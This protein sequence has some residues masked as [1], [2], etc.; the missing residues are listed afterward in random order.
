MIIFNLKFNLPGLALWRF[1]LARCVVLLFFKELCDKRVLVF[2]IL[3][4]PWTERFVPKFR[5]ILCL[6]NYSAFKSTK[7]FLVRSNGETCGK[8]NLSIELLNSQ[9][10]TIRASEKFKWFPILTKVINW[11]Q[12]KTTTFWEK[13]TLRWPPSG[14]LES[15]SENRLQPN[16][17]DSENTR[18]RECK[19]KMQK[20]NVCK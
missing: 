13:R 18:S 1:I 4:W 14:T 17:L 7:A 5:K 3:K 2:A 8:R 15:N 6:Q 20:A 16:G 10:N 19:N 9:E 12:R 11:S